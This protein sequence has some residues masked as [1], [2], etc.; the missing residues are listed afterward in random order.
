M[1]EI[2]SNINNWFQSM[3]VIGLA[4]NSCIESFF[5]LPPPDFLLIAMDLGM[6]A[7][8]ALL[9]GVFAMLFVKKDIVN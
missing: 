9:I 3:G 7:P 5:L 6:I 4:L 1:H 2:L 8:V